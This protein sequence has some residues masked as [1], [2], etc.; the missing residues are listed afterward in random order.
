MAANNAIFFF[1]PKLGTGL[2]FSWGSLAHQ[3]LLDILLYFI[4][5]LWS[6][7]S[8]LR[9]LSNVIVAVTTVILV[10]Y[11]TNCLYAHIW[12]GSPQYLSSVH[13]RYPA[14]YVNDH[15]WKCTADFLSLLVWR[16]FSKAKQF[17][18]CSPEILTPWKRLSTIKCSQ[19]VNKYLLQ[20]TKISRGWLGIFIVRTQPRKCYCERSSTSAHG[21]L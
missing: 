16:P 14:I 4:S 6:Y 5:M 17:Q 8:V 7:Y 11:S 19:K 18:Q 10:Y 2:M 1:A 21:K 3:Y 9:Q 15:I 12:L 13:D 20:L